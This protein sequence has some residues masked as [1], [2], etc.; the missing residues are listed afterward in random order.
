MS[1]TKYVLGGVLLGGIAYVAGCTVHAEPAP[2]EVDAGPVVYDDYYYHGY[3]DGPVYYWHDRYGHL[4][5]E[6]REM[7]ERR[8]MSEHRGHAEERRGGERHEQHREEHH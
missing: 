2:V 6:E 4:R 7:H 8:E 5:H 1:V 3:Y